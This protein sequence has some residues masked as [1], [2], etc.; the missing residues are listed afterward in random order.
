M[1]IHQLSGFILVFFFFLMSLALHGNRHIFIG[2]LTFIPNMNKI[3]PSFKMK[4]IVK[5]K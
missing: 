2:K 1:Q 5:E 3:T 4:E